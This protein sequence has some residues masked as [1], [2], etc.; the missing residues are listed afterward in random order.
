MVG[1]AV[2]YDVTDSANAVPNKS[3]T[4]C[5]IDLYV[6]EKEKKSPSEEMESLAH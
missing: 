4:R 5:Q 6:K 3:G 1:K 2:K